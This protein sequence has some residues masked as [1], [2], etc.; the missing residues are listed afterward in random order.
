[1]GDRR[2]GE[3]GQRKA[4]G[5]AAQRR[6][7]QLSGSDPHDHPDDETQRVHALLAARAVQ[8]E[9]GCDRSFQVP[10]DEAHQPFQEVPGQFNALVDG[11]WRE[12]ERG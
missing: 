7:R 8:G 1:M 5:P 3:G 2:R 9:D 11:F 4:A 6:D 10:E 12:V